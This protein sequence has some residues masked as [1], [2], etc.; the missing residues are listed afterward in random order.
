MQNIKGKAKNINGK[1]NKNANPQVSKKTNKTNKEATDEVKATDVKVY[2]KNAQFSSLAEEF[3]KLKQKV[4]EEMP[5]ALEIQEY[6]IPNANGM[7]L[8]NDDVEEIPK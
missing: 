7:Q 1:T 5:P 8:L 2:S 3:E 6:S 4:V